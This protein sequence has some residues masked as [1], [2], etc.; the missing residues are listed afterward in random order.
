MRLYLHP[1]V[2]A[3]LLSPKAAPV[4]ILATQVAFGVVDCPEFE[5]GFTGKTDI[6]QEMGSTVE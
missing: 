2:R 6:E 5:L 3:L 1:S 4:T